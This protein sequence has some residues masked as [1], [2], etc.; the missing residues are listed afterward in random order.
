M[1]N[2]DEVYKHFFPVRNTGLIVGVRARRDGAPISWRG[3]VPIFAQYIVLDEFETPVLDESLC[4]FET[5]DEALF[6]ADVYL[7][8][9]AEGHPCADRFFSAA[10]VDYVR[11]RRNLPQLVIDMHRAHDQKDSEAAMRSVREFFLKKD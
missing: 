5:G 7:A 6:V 1:T 3:H 4:W 8:L 2:S 11:Y 10:W 9:V